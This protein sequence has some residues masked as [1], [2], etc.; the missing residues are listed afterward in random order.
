MLQVRVLRPARGNRVA[1]LPDILGDQPPDNLLKP[2]PQLL[3]QLRRRTHL[4]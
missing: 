3:P 1:N 2:A 4:A